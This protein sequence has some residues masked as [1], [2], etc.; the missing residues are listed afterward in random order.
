MTKPVIAN[1]DRAVTTQIETNN[2]V[3]GLLLRNMLS[4]KECNSRCK[5]AKENE[6]CKGHGSTNPQR[7]KDPPPRPI[8]MMSQFETDEQHGQKT[9]ETNTTTRSRRFTIRHITY[10]SIG[11]SNVAANFFNFIDTC[12]MIPV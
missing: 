7:G 2:P 1:P 11:N 10:L 8:N 6:H 9:A 12:H 4:A 5:E 3:R